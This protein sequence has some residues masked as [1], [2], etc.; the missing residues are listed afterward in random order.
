MDQALPCAYVTVAVFVA[1]VLIIILF[2]YK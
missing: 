1:V 2:R